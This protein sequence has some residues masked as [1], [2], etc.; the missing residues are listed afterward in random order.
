MDRLSTFFSQ[1]TLSARVFFSGQLCGTSSDHA[2]RTAGHLHVVRNGVLKILQPAGPPIVIDE[3]AALLYPRAGRHTFQSD[4]AD[5]VCAFVEFGGGTLNPLVSVLPTLLMV[6]LASM[7]ELSPAVD[8]LFTE[9][10]S[11]RDGRQAAVDRLAE[12]FL[13]LLLRSAIDSRLLQGGILTAFSDARLAKAIDAMH[14]QPER[15]WTLDELAH[16]AG[17][18]RARFAAHF[19]A[20]T[21]QTPFQYLSLWRIGV[22]QSLLKKGQKLK[23]LAPCT[24]YASSGALTRAFVKHIGVTPMAWLAAQSSPGA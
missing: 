5:I 8:L 21:G 13:I 22:A 19:L 23:V 1:F 9:A 6:P 14:R 4:G 17:M 20:V 16:I 24:G 15:Q 2:S 11:K 7:P 18:S 3:P 10:F 12:Y